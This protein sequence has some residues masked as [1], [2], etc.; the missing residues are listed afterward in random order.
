[1]FAGEYMARIRPNVYYAKAQ[2]LGN[3]LRA[4]YNHALEKV[5]VLVMP[6]LPMRA[7]PNISPN[8]PAADYVG[9]AFEMLGN[10]CPTDI[11]HHP[12]INV[13]CAMADGLPVGMMLVGRLNEDATVIRAAA[14]FESLGDWREM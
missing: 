13:P 4:A 1:M 9:K 8:A 11:T 14:A 7:Q 10:T 5:D 3:A 6:T 2:N 12:A